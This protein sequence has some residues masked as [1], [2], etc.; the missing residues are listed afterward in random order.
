MRVPQYHNPGDDTS[1]SLSRGS[2]QQ[3]GDRGDKWVVVTSLPPGHDPCDLTEGHDPSDLC[4]IPGWTVLVVCDGE[5]P[6]T[7][8]YIT[9]L[10]CLLLPHTARYIHITLINCITF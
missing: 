2:N 3:R 10:T 6:H 9:Y 8:R 5:V 4:D 7:Q 1:I